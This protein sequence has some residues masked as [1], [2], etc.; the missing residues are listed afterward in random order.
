[1]TAFGLN[2]SLETMHDPQSMVCHFTLA[3]TETGKAVGVL[4][5][6]ERMVLWRDSTGQ[7]A[8]QADQCP[9]R[10]AALSIGA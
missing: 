2:L 9:H 1:L 7:P 6:G 10:G 4:R 8:C 3:R 5:M